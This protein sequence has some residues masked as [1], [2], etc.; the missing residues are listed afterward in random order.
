M[1]IYTHGL[2][3][4]RLDWNKLSGTKLKTGA[5]SKREYPKKF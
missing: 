4:K 5:K 2:R 3:M 1:A